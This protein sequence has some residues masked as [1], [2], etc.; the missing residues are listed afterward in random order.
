MGLEV[1]VGVV[2]SFLVQ[3][4]KKVQ[5]IK[6]HEGDKKKLRVVAAVLSFL[7]VAIVK[8]TNGE[9][10]DQQYIETVVQSLVSYFVSYLSYKSV[11]NNKVLRAA[12][13]SAPEGEI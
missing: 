13:L 9:L 10:A 11:I 1:L 6:L 7:G 8:W 12:T 2:V 3:G 5:R 4:A